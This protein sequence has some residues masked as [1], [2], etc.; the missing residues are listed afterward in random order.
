M[1]YPIKEACLFGFKRAFKTVPGLQ[2]IKYLCNSAAALKRKISGF[3]D[4][5]Q[6][7]AVN[8]MILLKTFFMLFPSEA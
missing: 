6:K 3:N 5:M 2:R 8:S 1:K 4:V 7:A